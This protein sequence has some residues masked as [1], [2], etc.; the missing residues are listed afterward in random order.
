M[1]QNT[2]RRVKKIRGKQLPLQAT[3]INF[4]IEHCLSSPPNKSKNTIPARRD[5]PTRRCT[6][7][8]AAELARPLKTAQQSSKSTPSSPWLPSWPQR[9][10]RPCPPPTGAE[11]ESNAPGDVWTRRCTPSPAAELA[12]PLKTAQQSSK[13]QQSS[14][15]TPP[16]A[17]L[18]P[19]PEPTRSATDQG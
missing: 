19:A 4:R 6:P 8:P 15:S 5:V 9:R 16:A 18:A 14:K 10:N 3:Q 7:S 11:T 17:E 13:Q 1:C 2:K 12:R